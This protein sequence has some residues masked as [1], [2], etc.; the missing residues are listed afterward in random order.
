MRTGRLGLVLWEPGSVIVERQVWHG[1]IAAA[2]PTVV[3][4]DTASHLV[5]FM[6]TGAPFGFVEEMRYPSPSGRHPRYGI[7]RWRGHGMLAIVPKTGCVSVQHY[8]RGESRSFTS[9]Y[10]NLQE[11]M[12]PTAIGFDSQDLELDIVI[13]PD[14]DWSLK[15]G[16]LLDQRVRE[17]RWT[18]DEARL[19]RA[20]AH[21]AIEDVL[22]PGRWWWEPCWSTWRPDG[23][24]APGLP[25]GWR[26]APV[27]A[28]PGLHSIDP[29]EWLPNRA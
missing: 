4:E 6:A 11:P 21:R 26:D 19:I 23:I 29:V 16:E 10:L 24:E 12:R 20:I 7:E 2:F 5:T 3:I 18:A 13:S 22:V 14:R 8:W 15:D 17:G 25:D 27:A 1:Q 28:F 9:W